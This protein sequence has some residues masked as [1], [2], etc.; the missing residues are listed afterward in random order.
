MV[1]FQTH[2]HFK[3]KNRLLHLL[4][5]IKSLEQDFQVSLFM[6]RN[7]FPTSCSLEAK[8]DKEMVGKLR[9]MAGKRPSL[10]GGPQ[11]QVQDSKDTEGP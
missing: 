3:D 6:L 8:E 1:T 7:I 9:T 5:Q 2:R 4:E 10:I 11:G